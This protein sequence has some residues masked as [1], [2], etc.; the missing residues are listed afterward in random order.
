M[1]E[2]PE[3]IR[4]KSAMGSHREIPN[5]FTIESL[6]GGNGIP[7]PGTPVRS[8]ESVTTISLAQE[9]LSAPRGRLLT[10]EADEQ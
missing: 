3:T 8:A 10:R 5:W 9:N 1:E 7:G 4:P 2:Q 6:L